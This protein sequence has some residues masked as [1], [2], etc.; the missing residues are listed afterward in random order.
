MKKYH[1][2]FQII[3]E[4]RL[5]IQLVKITF[6]QS[7]RNNLLKSLVA[8]ESST[9][10]TPPL[11][12]NVGKG[13]ELGDGDIENADPAY[14]SCGPN[15]TCFGSGPAL[16]FAPSASPLFRITSWPNISDFL[17]AGEF[18]RCSGRTCFRLTFGPEFP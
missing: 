13:N 16:I 18:R 15:R 9:A 4:H 12:K 17:G 6:C 5:Q 14:V 2:E 7:N 1:G 11:V 10:F 8:A 3:L